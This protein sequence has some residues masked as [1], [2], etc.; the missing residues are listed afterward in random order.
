MAHPQGRHNPRSRYPP[1]ENKSIVIAVQGSFGAEQLFEHGGGFDL[2]HVGEIAQ[3]LE[4]QEEVLQQFCGA[5]R[6]GALILDEEE[7]TF[8]Q[9][10]LQDCGGQGNADSTGDAT[11][12][13]EQ[14]RA[15]TELGFWQG[16]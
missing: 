6:H 14:T 5:K 1:N 11:I 4:V 8:G 9:T 3:V 13:T 10:V 12:Q 7:H 15:H 16:G 2:G